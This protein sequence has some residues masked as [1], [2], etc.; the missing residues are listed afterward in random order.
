MRE[1]GKAL[2]IG[3]LTG[4]L[5]AIGAR[6]DVPNAMGHQ[7]LL[8]LPDGSL[9][10]D[11]LY[12][13]SFG[14]W[15]A[16]D[17]EDEDGLRLFE[18][19]VTT[20]VA[21]GMYNVVLQ[22]GATTLADIFEDGPLFLE[23]E[24]V[25][26]PEGAL[27]GT[28]LEPRQ[29]VDS[30]PYAFSAARA[31]EVAGEVPAT[32]PTGTILLWDQ[33]TGCDGEA[34]ECPCGYDEAGEFRGRTLRGADGVGASADIP[35]EAGASLGMPDEA[36]RYGDALTATEAPTHAHGMTA[37]GGAHGHPLIDASAGE[38]VLRNVEASTGLSVFDDIR[39]TPRA[40][41]GT[42]QG[43]GG[44]RHDVSSSGGGPHYHPFRTVLFCRRR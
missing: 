41:F 17:D 30:V 43:A 38:L 2:A 23:V 18:E 27:N 4:S 33:G 10:P 32:V 40:G 28:V 15:D 12:E 34:R 8:V 13:L 9:A 11:G 42:T 31:E 14:I 44:H 36:G 39:N 29:Q 16:A 7:G 22:G 25:T 26:S 3:A 19:T 21:R 5:L 1:F 35:D 20:I 24:I 6:G 37:F